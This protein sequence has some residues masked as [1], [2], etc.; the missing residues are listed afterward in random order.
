MFWFHGLYHTTRLP[1][2]RPLS[3]CYFNKILDSLSPWC[4]LT[5][6]R[7]QFENISVLIAVVLTMPISG[8]GTHILSYLYSDNSYIIG[9]SISISSW[10]KRIEDIILL[11]LGQ[12]PI[13]TGYAWGCF[14]AVNRFRP[15][16]FYSVAH[17]CGILDVCLLVAVLETWFYF[18]C[19]CLSRWDC[20]QSWLVCKKRPFPPRYIFRALNFRYIFK[21][22]FLFL[23]Q[24]VLYRISSFHLSFD[25]DLLNH[26]AILFTI[27]AIW[28][29]WIQFLAYTLFGCSRSSVDATWWW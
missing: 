7:S 16:N 13:V 24:F 8:K 2:L 22:P 10:L 17:L 19:S 29:L 9:P 1:D 12:R 14:M 11:V 28:Y 26:P 25:N 5:I 3:V 18:H 4:S 23:F 21:T 15:I 6:F 27:E 20:E